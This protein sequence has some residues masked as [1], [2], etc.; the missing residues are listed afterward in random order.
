MSHPKSNP[1]TLRLLGELMAEAEE[2]RKERV[3][4][5]RFHSLE[6]Y[7]LLLEEG[8]AALPFEPRRANELATLGA[9]LGVRL[10][11]R[12]MLAPEAES[13]GLSRAL[14]LTATAR[15]LVGDVDAAEA[16]L[17]RAQCLTLEAAGRGRF[18]RALGLLRWDQ[19]RIPEAVALLHHGLLLFGQARKGREEAACRA[20]LG[21]LHV[22]E[23]EAERGAPLLQRACRALERADE[24]WLAARCGLGLAL[25]FAA[26]GEPEK[27][28][29]ARESAWKLYGGVRNEDALFAL[30]WMEGRVA[31]GAGEAT[32]AG[33]LLEAVRRKLIARRLLPEATL[34]TIDLGLVLT[35]LGRGGE[36]SAHVE[37]LAARFEGRPGLDLALGAL[38]T[39]AE[40]AAA[41]R[42]DR[43][44][45]TRL[46]PELR[47]AFRLQGV[48][49]SP[50]PFA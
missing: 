9:E 37:E 38:A 34:A 6:L 20:L 21:L 29:R 8:R 41:G 28:K 49:L 13:E 25:C 2:E 44:L 23:G 45:W 30:Y 50:V 7:E 4:E 15:R 40:D 24:A 35:E 46:A 1:R 42:L 43:H 26:A 10:G 17:E 16:L 11:E 22:E 19:G 12:G 36:V 5:E 32:E 18:C 27:A 31:A 33:H 48:G 14:C 47:L 39:Y 3:Q